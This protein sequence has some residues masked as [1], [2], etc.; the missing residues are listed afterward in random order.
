LLPFSNKFFESSS[1]VCIC[2]DLHLKK[3]SG[4]G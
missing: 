2:I 3:A 4:S 1:I